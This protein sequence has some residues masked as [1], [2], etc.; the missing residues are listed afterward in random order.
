LEWLTEQAPATVLIGMSGNYVTGDYAADIENRLVRSVDI[1]ESTGHEVLLFQAIPQFPQWSPF[2][3]TLFDVMSDP[4]GCGATVAE[5]EMDSRQQ[6]ALTLFA[7]VS[8]LTGAH[9]VDFRSELRV[10]GEYATNQGNTWNYRDM[11]H[12][13]VTKSEKL[14]DS[15][16]SALEGDR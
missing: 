11:F 8:D 7:D 16:L 5:Q 3:C 10:A 13:S 12:I 15:M 9:L 4:Q 1:L 14:R 2:D 6:L